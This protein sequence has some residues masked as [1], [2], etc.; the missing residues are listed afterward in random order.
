MEKSYIELKDTFKTLRELNEKKIKDI[1]SLNENDISDNDNGEAVPYTKDDEIMNSIIE[2]AKIQFGAS[3]EGFKN[4][5]LYYPETRNVTLCGMIPSMNNL[6]FQFSF[7]EPS[8]SIF[9]WTSPLYLNDKSLD[10]LNKMN[11]VYKNWIT[12]L[13][14]SEDIKPMS[15]K[16]CVSDD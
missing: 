11:G 15:L 7:L 16:K 1:V 14:T 5:M 9:I 10:T 6:K 3:F 13:K 4:P 2:T 8:E 12:E